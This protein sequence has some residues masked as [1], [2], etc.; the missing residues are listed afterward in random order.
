MKKLILLTGLLLMASLLTACGSSGLDKDALDVSWE[1]SQ[2]TETLPASQSVVPNP[3]N[4]TLV[5]L[6]DGTFGLNADCNL[7]SG[8]YEVD[9]DNLTLIL[10]IS[11]MAFCGEESLDTL[12]LQMLESVTSYELADGNLILYLGED[13]GKMVFADGGAVEGN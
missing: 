3:E 2:L 1:W 6:A 8:E 7:V 4:Y 5:F 12:Y 10:G 13:A 11:T 9:G